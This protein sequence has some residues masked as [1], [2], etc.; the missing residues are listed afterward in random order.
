MRRISRSSLI[1]LGIVMEKEP[2]IQ[3]IH[4]SGDS[5][6]DIVKTVLYLSLA[7]LVILIGEDKDLLVLLLCHYSRD[8]HNEVYM[9]TAS[10]V[11]SINVL[12]ETIGK[13]LSHSLLFLHALKVVTQH[14]GLMELAKCLNL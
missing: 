12:Q 3:A 13:D 9:Q 14:Q 7:K 5:D 4:S 6:L 8:V 10:K 2:S 1:L 11:I